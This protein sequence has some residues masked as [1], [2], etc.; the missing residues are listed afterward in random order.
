MQSIIVAI[1]FAASIAWL[2]WKYNPKNKNITCASGCDCTSD[3]PS[4][5]AHL[6]NQRSKK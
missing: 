5:P 4:L 2:F 3:K 6:Q 1:L